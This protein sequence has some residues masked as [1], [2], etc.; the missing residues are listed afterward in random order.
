MK[1]FMHMRRYVLLALAVMCVTLLAMARPFFVPQDY[2][3][4]VL[5]GSSVMAADRFHYTISSPV[6]LF[7]GSH[8]VIESGTLGLGARTRT[9]VQGG[10]PIEE[11]VADG[12]AE[13]TLADARITVDLDTPGA[14]T[15]GPV[16]ASPL[17]PLATAL[18][19]LKLGSL[20]ISGGTIEI[21]AGPQS[22]EVLD[23][24]EVRVR[25]ASSDTVSLSGTFKLRGRKLDFD[26]KLNIGETA[27]K[28]RRLPIQAKIRGE[29]I[30]ANLR[31]H[32][33]GGSRARLVAPGSELKLTNLGEAARWL[34][35]GWPERSAIQAFSGVGLIDWSA[36]VLDFQDAVF[37]FDRNRA[38]GAMTFN[39]QSS[40]PQID[41][42]LAFER[43]DLSGILAAHTGV[44]DSIIAAAVRESTSWLPLKL[45]LSAE[46]MTIPLLRE[47]DADL[48]LSAEQVQVGSLPLG[49]SA[50]AVSLRDGKMLA[51][52][53][54]LEFEGGGE[55]TVQVSVDAN[56]SPPEL[57]V[58]GRLHGF[59]TGNL[60]V[61]LIGEPVVSGRGDV[62]IDVKAAG[63]SYADL[64]RSLAGR[65]EARVTEGA[66][67]AIDV[68]KLIGKPGSNIGST[69]GWGAGV[70]LTRL[71]EIDVKLA[72]EDGVARAE[73]FSAK[74]GAQ[75]LLGGGAINVAAKS[76]DANLWIGA[77]TPGSSGE[78]PIGDLVHFEGDWHAPGISISRA[79]SRQAVRPED[80]TH[81]G[82]RG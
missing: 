29:L 18:V 12:E 37:K 13:L 69:V 1:R 40:R 28:E 73:A 52:L 51:D 20:A 33:S 61:A 48:R 47:V 36:G 68:A 64:T 11:I 63:D 57:G 71:D 23:E 81:D 41:G 77:D 35:V 26:T 67:L 2:S 38:N 79:P 66:A 30:E 6:A 56:S 34:G 3:E 25:H 17:A 53:A 31:G 5:N 7:G 59:E 80:K 15:G 27:R 9:A 46:A 58:R 42:T 75:R 8:V 54:E 16:Q 74:M 32:L 55:G 60:S 4:A 50:A 78:A 70:G 65:I 49:R 45:D 62:L 22:V 43:L 39:Y 76:L 19:D 72:I 14:E 44:S 21:K 10:E 24:L 82:G